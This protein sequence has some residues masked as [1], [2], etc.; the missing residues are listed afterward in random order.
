MPHFDKDFLK[1]PV[2]GGLGKVKQQDTGL[3]PDLALSSRE[4]GQNH[5]T[6]EAHATRARRDH[7]DHLLIFQ[8]RKWGPEMLT[9]GH[10]EPLRTEE[11]QK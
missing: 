1:E 10:R 5:R 11:K 7:Q 6:S 3:E 8:R 9:P 4:S 2:I